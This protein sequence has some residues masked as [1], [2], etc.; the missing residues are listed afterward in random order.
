MRM[1]AAAMG[2]FVKRDMV[3]TPSS[4]ALVAASSALAGGSW[5]AAD[6]NV[7][8]QMISVLICVCKEL[9]CQGI[10][11]IGRAADETL[12]VAGAWSSRR[13]VAFAAAASPRVDVTYVDPDKFTDVRNGYTPTPSA[14]DFYL[15]ELK[16]FIESRAAA[17]MADGETL[18]I[19]ITNVQLEG[20]YKARRPAITNVRIVRDVNPARIDLRFRLVRGETCAR[21][22]APAPHNR[23]SR[24]RRRRPRATHCST[25][26][27]CSTSGCAMK[28]H[29][30]RL[31]ASAPGV[32]GSACR[33]CPTA[34]AD[35]S[36]GRAVH[37]IAECPRIE[38]IE[39]RSR[40]FPYQI[41]ETE[42]DKIAVAVN[43]PQRPDRRQRRLLGGNRFRDARAPERR[44]FTFLP[45]TPAAAVVRY[46][47]VAQKR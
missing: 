34:L 7:S 26:R 21:G 8:T 28:S 47:Q 11:P 33:P 22:G 46:C 38:L 13:V 5:L 17:R 29:S 39:H 6:A 40:G 25:S 18:T 42:F 35:K 9:G 27:R 2:R 23:L 15:A 32:P 24:G 43:R 14:R 44:I 16:R 31:S 41:Q 37:Q 30:H 10:W 4:A 19:A 36:A 12:P 45:F 20:D 1:A 3:G